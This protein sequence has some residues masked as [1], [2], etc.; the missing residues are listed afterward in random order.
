MHSVTSIEDIFCE[1]V[2]STSQLLV[3][4]LIFFSA[5]FL[6]LSRK[7]EIRPAIN[8]DKNMPNGITIAIT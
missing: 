3:S 4:S 2:S 6:H 8:I 1:F 7:Q 5:F